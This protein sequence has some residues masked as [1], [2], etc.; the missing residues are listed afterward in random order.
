MRS[1]LTPKKIVDKNG[2]HTTVLINDSKSSARGLPT[3][4]AAPSQPI[5]DPKAHLL[6][7]QVDEYTCDNHDDYG[8]RKGCVQGLARDW[9]RKQI[10][11]SPEQQAII[12]AHGITELDTKRIYGSKLDGWVEWEVRDKSDPAKRATVRVPLHRPA[13]VD[14]IAAIDKSIIPSFDSPDELS[15]FV[16]DLYG[17]SN[18]TL[19]FYEQGRHVAQLS[20]IFVD[21]DLRGLG[22]GNHIMQMISRYGD[23]H[24]VAITLSPTEGGD[25]SIYP[26]ATNKELFD[27]HRATH[28]SRVWS[29]YESHG[30]ERNMAYMGYF[31]RVDTDS[32]LMGDPEFADSL[33]ADYYSEVQGGVMVR[34]PNGKPSERFFKKVVAG[35]SI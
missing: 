8:C 10:M 26:D 11:S 25:G 14:D 18:V 32:Q 9:A 3:V 31:K 4:S 16:E 23:E 15:A 30:Y 33:D 1:H 24:D 12:A 29:Y 35:Q 7:Q 19:T 20:D 34:Y 13:L 17:S 28:Q 27:K 6:S 21:A 22:V 5:L 2:R